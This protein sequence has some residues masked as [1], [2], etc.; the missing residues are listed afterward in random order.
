MRKG[1]NNVIINSPG[2]QHVLHHPDP[3]PSLLGLHPRQLLRQGALPC[4]GPGQYVER[5]TRRPEMQKNGL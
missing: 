5:E 1:D 3:G 2:P 4:R